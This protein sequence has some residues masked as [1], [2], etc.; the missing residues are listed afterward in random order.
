[1]IRI[2]QYISTDALRPASRRGMSMQY[3]TPLDP[4][5][6]WQIYCGVRGVFTK[7]QE[8]YRVLGNAKWRTYVTA[9]RYS[10][11]RDKSY[12]ENALEVSRALIGLK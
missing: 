4:Y 12:E 6:I 10:E 9:E 11:F 3:K 1:M 5:E 8:E 7:Y 2:Q